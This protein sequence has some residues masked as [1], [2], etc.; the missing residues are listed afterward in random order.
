M[1]S[2]FTVNASSSAAEFAG[3]DQKPLWIVFRYINGADQSTAAQSSACQ[4]VNSF[5]LTVSASVNIGDPIFVTW[6]ASPWCAVSC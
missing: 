3:Y 6:H 4:I 2:A 5:S 1:V